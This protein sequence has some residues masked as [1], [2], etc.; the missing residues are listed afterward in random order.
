METVTDRGRQ[1]CRL[2]LNALG[3]ESHFRVGWLVAVPEGLENFC[4]MCA[5]GDGIGRMRSNLMM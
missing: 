1:E 5:N 4:L 3:S 2:R